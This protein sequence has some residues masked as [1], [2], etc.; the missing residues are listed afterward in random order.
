MPRGPYNTVTTKDHQRILSAY[1]EDQ[2]WLLLATQL[3]IKRQTARNIVRIFLKDNRERALPK[4]GKR[5]KLLDASMIQCLVDFLGN[6]AT[7]TL[8]EMRVKLQQQ[9][10][11]APAV[12]LSTISRALDGQ[13]ITLKDVRV[14]PLNWNHDEVKFERKMYFDWLLNDAMGENLIFCDEFGCNIWTARTKGRS[15]LGERAVR[16]VEGQRG[17]N[18]TVRLAIS[19]QWGLVHRMFVV[20]G[21]TQECFSDFVSELEAIVD[22]PF[23]L[24]CDNARPH[25]GVL[26]TLEQHHKLHYLPRYS[27]FLNCAEMAGSA[28][29]SASKQ[30]ISDAVIQEELANH[31]IAHQLR[32]TLHHYRMAILQREMVKALE[33]VTQTKC[34]QWFHHCMSYAPRCLHGEDIFA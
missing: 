8:A 17:P 27:P 23:T 30:T 31:E 26:G 12:S 24:V 29:K 25:C 10:P 14:V 11:F 2:D 15:F 19:P 28:M 16:V 6:K 18:L 5:P 33:N 22:A 9:F 1:K 20:G 7:A 13:M 4:G 3:G 21:F 32:Q 34:Q